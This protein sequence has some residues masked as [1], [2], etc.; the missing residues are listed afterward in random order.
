MGERC[1]LVMAI[2]G[3][4]RRP[5]RLN[6]AGPVRPATSSLLVATLCL[7]LGSVWFPPPVLATQMNPP[8]MHGLWYH[9]TN[10]PDQDTLDTHGTMDEARNTFDDYTSGY[11]THSNTTAS[12]RIALN[13]S[14]AETDAI[15]WLASHGCEGCMWLQSSSGESDIW[16]D[17][18]NA[19]EAVP[20]RTCNSMSGRDV[21]L[22][23]KTFSQMHDIRLMVFMGCNTGGVDHWGRTFPAYVTGVLGVDS[24]VG[25][26]DLIAFS[27]TTSNKWSHYFSA[28][29]LLG[30][31]VSDSAYAAAQAVLNASGGYNGYNSYVTSG[32]G[33]H[34]T[35][36]SYGS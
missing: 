22:T 32:G 27:A 14:Y 19:G 13:G 30:S 36:A 1:D 6:M 28:Y 7:V 2:T 25:F 20:P 15:W 18:H 31:N 8:W 17:Y 34:I 24:A 11:T 16:R 33:T 23:E 9:F 10:P 26:S 12:A 3:V 29:N 35:P 4:A 5:R 21:C